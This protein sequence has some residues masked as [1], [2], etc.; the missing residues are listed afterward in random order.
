MKK[1]KL[2]PK[3]IADTFL[4]YALLLLVSVVFLFPCLWLVLSCFSASGSIYSFNGFFPTEYSLNSFK[5][6][7][8]DS[9]Y[10]YWSWFKNTLLI[11]VVSS[12]LGTL[13]VVVTAFTISTFQFK[14]RKALMKGA[15]ALGMFPS[16][17][18]MT[19]VYLLMTQFNFINSRIGLA[20]IYACGAPMGYLVQK[21]FFDTIPKTIYDAA[22]IDGA[23]NLRIFCSV[24]LPL[25]KPILVY[26]LLTQFAWPWSDYILPKLLLKDRELWTVAM[27]LM[28]LPDTEFARFAA[29]SVFIGVP[30]VV[31][32]FCLT[33]YMVNVLSAGAV[34]E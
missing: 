16:F 32:Y 11:A 24:T 19:A 22:K 28:S 5:S 4:T 21:G 26:T 34:K 30:I 14:G 23:S 12:F 7:F 1:L 13:L 18:G 3:R 15:L 31:L 29:G 6:L 10:N 9:F 27:G 8:T 20:L 17:M 25:S 2:R 33:K